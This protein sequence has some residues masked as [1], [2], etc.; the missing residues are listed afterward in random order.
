MSRL[1]Y[2]FDKSEGIYYN[3]ALG[4]GEYIRVVL[5]GDHDAAMA[6]FDEM[7][8]AVERAR[9]YGD[10][11]TMRDQIDDLLLERSKLYTRV[12][13]LVLL[14]Q[15]L[16]E[17]ANHAPQCSPDDDCNCELSDAQY[18]WKAYKDQFEQA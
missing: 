1:P 5:A 2:P 3:V 4:N 17:V 9:S 12:N 8:K 6:D 15:E 13:D 7:K 18:S 11:S 16:Y 10:E 14:G